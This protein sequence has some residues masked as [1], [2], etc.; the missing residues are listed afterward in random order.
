ML[1]LVD[2]VAIFRTVSPKVDCEF[3]EA[4]VCVGI[5]FAGRSGQGIPR[6]ILNKKGWRT[7]GGYRRAS[8]KNLSNAK[9]CLRKFKIDFGRHRSKYLDPIYQIFYAKLPDPAKNYPKRPKHPFPKKC[10]NPAT[11]AKMLKIGR[12]GCV[13]I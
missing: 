13:Y 10:K 6:P 3:S 11:N 2:L 8:G 9:I 7:Y 4:D 1:V 5:F 12:S